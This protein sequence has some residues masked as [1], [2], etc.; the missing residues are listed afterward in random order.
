[1]A[2]KD[3]Y[4]EMPQ[5]IVFLHDLGVDEFVVSDLVPVSRGRDVMDNAMTQE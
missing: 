1:M 3:T 2:L 4:S 5:R